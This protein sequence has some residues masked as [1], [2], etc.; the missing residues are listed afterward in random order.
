M[1]VQ[2]R[3]LFLRYAL[4]CAGTLVKRGNVSQAYLDSTIRL[5]S[6][7]KVPN[8]RAEAIFKVANAMC[9]MLAEREGKTTIDSDVI[10]EYFLV[11]HSRVVDDRFELMGDFDPVSCKTYVGVVRSVDG[12][13]ATVETVLGKNAYKTLFVEDTKKGDK[14]IVHYDFIIEKAS[15]DVLKW[16]KK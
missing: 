2:D 9:G 5:V 3:L 13:S 4:P 12:P 14:V 15:P 1:I 6:E 10:R 8:E 16:L 11:E 7:G